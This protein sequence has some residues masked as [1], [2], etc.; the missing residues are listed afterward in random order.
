MHNLTDSGLT[1]YNR[2]VLYYSI[3]ITFTLSEKKQ[4]LYSDYCQFLLSSFTNFTQTYMADH[5]DKWSHDQINR[6]LSGENIPANEL[7]NSVKNDIEFDDD[8]YIVFD[9]VVLP[10]LYA[11][12]IE[13]L[14]SQWSGSDKKVVKGIGIVTCIYVNPKTEEYWIIDYRIYDIDHDGKTK[15]DHLLEM[16]HN[17]Y[18]KKQLPFRTVLMDTWYASMQVMKAIEKLSKIYYVPLKRNRLV[19]D[20]DGEQPHQQ[21]QDLSWTRTE[22]RQGKSVHIK[23]FPKGYQVKLFRIASSTGRT[24]Y[25]VTNDLSQSDAD[26]AH[27]ECRIRWKIEQLHREIKQVTGIGKCQC[28]KLRAQRNHIACC[29]QIWVC[30]KRVA[31]KLGKTIY[32]LK[33][34]LLDDYMRYQ[35]SNP[36]IIFETA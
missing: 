13:V 28:R 20:T 8:G 16:L 10:K 14:R 25:I 9:D 21:V 34:S 1:H 36:S 2:F 4:S 23:K 22:I 29:F 17:A 19:N 7:W 35:L 24:E 30:L 26:A 11:K 6:F 31:R 33:Q 32:E 15:I 5:T 3:M 27:Q 12:E 18:S